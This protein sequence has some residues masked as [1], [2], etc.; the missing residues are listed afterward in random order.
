LDVEN[1]ID[2]ENKKI[3]E[4]N[5]KVDKYNEVLENEEDSDDEF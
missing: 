5:K 2:E 3:D 4:Y 1:F